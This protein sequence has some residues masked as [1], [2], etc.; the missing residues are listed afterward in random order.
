MILKAGS[1]HCFS[2][3]YRQFA[4]SDGKDSVNEVQCVSHSSCIRV[5]TEI[6]AS[7]FF[8]S[9][10]QKHPG[11]LLVQGDLDERIMLVVFESDVVP[12]FVFVNEVQLQHEGLH[13]GVY[14]HVL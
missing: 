14:Q 6:P 9:P 12:R 3:L 11:V 5:R 2:M 8:H 13:L 1:C 10:D 7:I 4:A